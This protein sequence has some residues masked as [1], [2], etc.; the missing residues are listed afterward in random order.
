MGLLCQYRLQEAGLLCRVSG[1]GNDQLALSY[2]LALFAA[3]EV[4][5]SRFHSH[6]GFLLPH[7][8]T[9]QCLSITN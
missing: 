4:T 8:Y 1:I 5:A 9:I 6:R 3:L 2:Y 7:S